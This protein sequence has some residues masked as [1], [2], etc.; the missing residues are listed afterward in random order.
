MRQGF[1]TINSV[2]TRILTWGKWIT[3]EFDET[4]PSLIIFVSGLPG[5]TLCY[6]KFIETI[7]KNLNN[8][9]VWVIGL[10]GEEI[11][12]YISSIFKFIRLSNRPR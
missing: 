4:S 6:K 3:D 7:H 11:L 2:P 1:V 9:P 12:D 5:V 8:I 10:A